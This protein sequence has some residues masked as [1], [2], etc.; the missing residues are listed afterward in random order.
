MY[1]PSTNVKYDKLITEI[2]RPKI[3]Y[4][5]IARGTLAVLND[6]SDLQGSAFDTR[7]LFSSEIMYFKHIYLSH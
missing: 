6:Y 7:A 1:C 5:A 4:V 3:K 2:I